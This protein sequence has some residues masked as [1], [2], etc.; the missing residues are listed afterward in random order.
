MGK[1]WDFYLTDESEESFLHF[2][3]EDYFR[4]YANE[5]TE[6]FFSYVA[7]P[8][9]LKKRPNGQIFTILEFIDLFCEKES[10]EA[11]GKGCISLT[12][13]GDGQSLT[14][15]GF[16]DIEEV[17]DEMNGR[18][19]S[20][21][22]KYRSEITVENP[23][24]HLIYRCQLEKKVP[25]YIFLESPTD[26]DLFELR[27]NKEKKRLQFYLN[28]SHRL[29]AYDAQ[30]LRIQLSELP[31]KWYEFEYFDFV[32]GICRWFEA[33]VL[34]DAFG[35]FTLVAEDLYGDSESEEIEVGDQLMAQLS[36]LKDYQW[37]KIYIPDVSEEQMREL[38]K[39]NSFNTHATFCAYI[40]DD[41]LAEDIEKIPVF[42]GRDRLK[43]PN[44]S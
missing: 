21:F 32:R 16:E 24:A 37:R 33:D 17:F 20:L 28:E 8:K 31:Y 42:T 13:R 7:Q 35:G 19:V 36:V 41:D 2:E 44:E 10:M 9:L 25:Q 15:D 34:A 26:A 30:E 43:F 14:L 1:R 18:G 29:Q 11:H 23:M 39:D 12:L 5:K 38:I 6:L 40:N 3:L 22:L 27:Y 4:T